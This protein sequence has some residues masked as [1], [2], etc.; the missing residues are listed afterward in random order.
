MRATKFPWAKKF[1]RTMFREWRLAATLRR[2]RI[3]SGRTPRARRSRLRRQ[4]VVMRVSWI[5]CFEGV[6]AALAQAL[7]EAWAAGADT[8][9]VAAIRASGR[10]RRA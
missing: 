1:F 5:A 6:A 7:V 9:S 4:R 10:R 3:R 8:A 2:L